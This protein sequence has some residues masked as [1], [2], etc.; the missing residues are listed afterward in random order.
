MSGNRPRL[1]LPSSARAGE[2][3]EIRALIEHPMETGLRRDASGQ[4]IPRDILVRLLVRANGQQAFAADLRNGASANPYHVF[5]LRIEQTTELEFV[6]THETGA[7]F[8]AAGR[9]DVA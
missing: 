6:W 9:I 7:T 5:Y 3:V 4:P 8:R 1:R 2:I